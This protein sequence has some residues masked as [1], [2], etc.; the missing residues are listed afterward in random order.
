[1][2]GGFNRFAHSAGPGVEED[3]GQVWRH[4]WQKWGSGGFETMN[5]INAKMVPKLEAGGHLRGKGLRRRPN[6][7]AHVTT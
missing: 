3:V 1:M 5:T 2:V 6:I 7:D 4:L